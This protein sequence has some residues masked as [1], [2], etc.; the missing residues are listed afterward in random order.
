M[1]AD[2]AQ[3]AGRSTRELAHKSGGEDKLVAEGGRDGTPG[4]EECFQ[5][6]LGRLLKPEGGF[7]PIAPVR[8]T[9]RQEAAF[10]NP[11]TVFVP[12]KLH[13]RKWNGH[14]GALVVCRLSGVKGLLHA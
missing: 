9:T 12:M 5:M 1:L 7:A 3:A 11:D 6:H 4:F 8:V 2:G 13:F 10:G 14:N